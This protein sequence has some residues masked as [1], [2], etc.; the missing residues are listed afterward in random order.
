VVEKEASELR[1]TK[2]NLEKRL[3]EAYAKSQKLAQVEADRKKL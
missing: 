2:A 1:T 3:T